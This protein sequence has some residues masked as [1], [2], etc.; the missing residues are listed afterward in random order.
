MFV[1]DV[2][3]NDDGA[4]LLVE[5]DVEVIE[6]KIKGSLGKQNNDDED[7]GGLWESG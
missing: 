4:H 2:Q 5:A 7:S 6:T 1:A 3:D